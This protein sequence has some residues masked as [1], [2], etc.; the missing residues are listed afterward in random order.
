MISSKAALLYISLLQPTANLIL[1]RSITVAANDSKKILH[2]PIIPHNEVIRRNRRRALLAKQKNNKTR[3][4]SSNEQDAGVEWDREEIAQSEEVGDSYYQH[5]ATLEVGGLYQ[6]YG[7]HYV[8]LWVGTPPQRQTVIVDTGSGVTAFPCS[9]CQDCGSKYHVDAFFQESQSSTFEK[10]G[11][12][13]CVGASCRGTGNSEG[14]CHLSVSYQEGSMWNAYEGQDVTYVGG[15]H[16]N[17][18]EKNN[19]EEGTKIGG[20]IHGEDPLNAA[21][22]EFNMVFGCQTKITGLFKTQLVSS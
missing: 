17:S 3:N 14:Y 8:D 7:T 20:S 4:L 13:Q 1:S 15:L 22:Y 18:V 16:D 19:K 6:G 2:F 9:G 10:F 12:D 5:N 11:C 21:D